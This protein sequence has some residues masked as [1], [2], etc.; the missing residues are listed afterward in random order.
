MSS[1]PTLTQ[2]ATNRASS[3][4]AE[5]SL[6][7][8][9]LR[10]LHLG[11]G[12]LVVGLALSG[13]SFYFRKPLGVQAFKLTLVY[14]HAFIAYCFLLV[15]ALRIAVGVFGDRLERVSLAFP[16]KGDLAALFRI[17][18]SAPRKRAFAGR[19]PL[20]RAISGALY[21]AFLV[22]AATG[23]V[24]LAT[25]LYFP[26]FGGLVRNYLAPDGVPPSAIKP[27]DPSLADK[28]RYRLISRAKIPFGKVHIYTAFVIV[29][30]S[31]AHATGVSLTE[32]SAPGTSGRRGRARLMLFGPDKR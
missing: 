7:P 24:R 26:P 8:L 27:A 5:P 12:L 23:S 13:F 30:L 20:S 9:A 15:V 18:H 19:S 17:G 22:M 4:A 16:R 3:G 21:A 14:I 2:A 28:A 1:Q 11:I 6:Y 31:G 10:R 29:I 32:W 25:D